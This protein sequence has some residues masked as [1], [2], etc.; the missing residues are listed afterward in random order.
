[1]RHSGY[2]AVHPPGPASVGGTGKNGQDCD[3]LTAGDEV[4][5]DHMGDGTFATATGIDR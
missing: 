5:F 2:R 4:A 3:G 1:M